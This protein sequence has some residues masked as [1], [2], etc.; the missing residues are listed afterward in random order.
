M[1]E[2]LP[3]S[4][5]Q[6]LSTLEL[7]RIKAQVVEEKRVATQ[8]ETLEE[9]RDFDRFAALLFLRKQETP[10]TAPSIPSYLQKPQSKPR[11]VPAAETKRTNIEGAHIVVAVTENLTSKE[12]ERF[13]NLV[14][15]KLSNEIK[16]NPELSNIYIGYCNTSPDLDNIAIRFDCE[17]LTFELK[18]AELTD[19]QTRILNKILRLVSTSALKQI[20][21]ERQP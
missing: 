19:N 14:K 7:L 9:K 18:G 21:S 3:Q 13:I 16:S 17:L 4:K 6:A 12:A 1:S 8:Q 15:R 5:Y 20:I 10:T 2:Q 11:E